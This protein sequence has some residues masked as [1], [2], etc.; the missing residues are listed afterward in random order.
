LAFDGHAGLELALVR[1]GCANRTA[2]AIADQT[3]VRL[4]GQPEAVYSFSEK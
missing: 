2:G 3:K 4:V 1:E